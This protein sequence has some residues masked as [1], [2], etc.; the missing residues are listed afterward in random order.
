MPTDENGGG[1]PDDETLMARLQGGDDS[2]LAELMQRWEIPAKRFLFRMVGNTAE[3]EDLAQEAFVRIYTKRGTYR[4]GAR[5]SS[6][7]FA[8]AANQAKNRLR[9]WKRRP[10]LSLDGWVDGGGDAEDETASPAAA[11]RAR[12]EAER[13]EAVQ[14]AVTALPLDQRT[15][16]VL[17]AYEG[18]TMAEIA[19][20]VGCSTKAVENR[21]Y[22]A[23]LRLRALA[24][25]AD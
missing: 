11:A 8:I 19:E 23:R 16:I 6:W 3:A 20:I 10:T 14:R 9:W 2:A 17:F 18:K 25:E 12:E 7:L 1:G 4:T 21:L 13:R 5:F 15:A 22:R 24:G